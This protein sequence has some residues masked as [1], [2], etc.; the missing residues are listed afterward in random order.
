MNQ[1][2]SSA[3]RSILLLLSL[4]S[5]PLIAVAEE[6]DQDASSEKASEQES[7]SVQDPPGEWLDIQIDTE[8]VSWSTV[9]ISPDGET[10]VFDLLGDL[11]RVPLAGGEAEALTEGIAW[12][13]QPVFSPDGSRIAFVSDRG[14]AENI[15]TIAADGGEPHQVTDEK[16][17]LLHNP[18]W[19]PDGQFIAG[20]ISEEER[21]EIVR[22][23]C[24][25]AG[26]CGGMYTANTMATA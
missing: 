22:R 5:A 16:E 12:D 2:M 24:P 7:W 1:S 6:H 17:N 18:A 9:T 10:V 14:G 11:Y 20:Q 19:T 15:W 25:G 3:C 4:S 21:Q 23:S 8:E 26:A 13:F